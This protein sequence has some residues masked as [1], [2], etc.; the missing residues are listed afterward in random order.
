MRVAD[1]CGIVR[2]DS[3]L[4][5]FENALKMTGRGGYV[6]MQYPADSLSPLS[7]LRNMFWLLFSSSFL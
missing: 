5:W 7:H 3:R 4:F 6:D 1:E 2:N